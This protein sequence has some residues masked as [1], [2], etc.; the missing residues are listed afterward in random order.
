MSHTVER[1]ITANKPL[2]VVWEYLS[3]FTTTTEW[4]PGTVRTVRTSGDGDVG[5]S[6]LNTS[7]FAGHEVELTYSVT[8]FEPAREITLHGSNDSIE[9]VDTMVFSGDEFETVV[10]YTATFTPK[11]IAKLAAPLLPFALKRLADE[12]KDSMQEHLEKL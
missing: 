8:A 9:T 5:T 11:G 6:Y 2:T 7:R 4:D 3:D 12:T 1:T 10:V